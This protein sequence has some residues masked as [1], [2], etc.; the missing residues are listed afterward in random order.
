M[1]REPTMLSPTPQPAGEVPPCPVLVLGLGNILLR[2]EGV[3]VHVATALQQLDLPPGVECVDGATAGLDLLDILAHREKVIVIDAVDSDH[4][5]GTVLRLTPDD[6]APGDAPDTSLH[7]IGLLETL[8]VARRLDISPR[9]V[10]VL[11][12]RPFVID[13]GLELSPQLG[14]L[15]PRILALVRAEIDSTHPVSRDLPQGEG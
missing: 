15:L 3:G 8:L 4:A 14:A 7:D 2:D 11:G 5:P 13:T 9:E 1:E 6:L 10:V 12:V